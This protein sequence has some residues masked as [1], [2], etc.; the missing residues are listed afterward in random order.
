MNSNVTSVEELPGAGDAPTG[1]TA[2][3]LG[4]GSDASTRQALGRTVWGLG[5]AA[6]YGAV[7]GLR[8]D[9]HHVALNALGVPAAHVAV[10]VLGVPALYIVLALQDAPVDPRQVLGA[11]S[12]AAAS[13]GIALAGLAPV[14]GLFMVTSAS[15]LEAVLAAGAGLLVGGGVGLVRLLRELGRVAQPRGRAQP[16]GVTFALTGFGF[17]AVLLAARVWLTTLSIF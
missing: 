13:S 3:L 6:V 8:H 14:A 11:V 10:A 4:G 5:L 15:G 17:F 9:A 2:E 1:F 16:A 7:L 12:R